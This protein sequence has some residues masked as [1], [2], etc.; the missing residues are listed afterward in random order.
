MDMNFEISE[1]S[2]KSQSS[3]SG[4]LI[5]MISTTDCQTLKDVMKR[6]YVAEKA[7]K[8]FESLLQHSKSGAPIDGYKTLLKRNRSDRETLVRELQNLPPCTDPDF[9]NHFSALA[10]NLLV[11]EKILNLR[12]LK[13]RLKRTKP[14]NAVCKDNQDDFVFPKK[15]IRP[16]SPI[17]TPEPVLTQNNFGNLEQD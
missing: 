13:L 1:H 6:I 15:T 9:P 16:N 12:K 7:I 10:E 8:R 2:F 17:K 11:L 4:T 14:K 3:R 5:S